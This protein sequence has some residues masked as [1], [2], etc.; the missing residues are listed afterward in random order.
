MIHDLRDISKTR[1]ILCRVRPSV[2]IH[3][4]GIS[5]PLAAQERPED[6]NLLHRQVTR[7]IAK[8]AE[9]AKA[10]V[11]FASSDFV[12]GGDSEF[13]YKEDDPA[14]PKT[15]YGKSKLAGEREILERKV[16]AVCRFSFLWGHTESEREGGWNEVRRRLESGETVTGITDEL[17]S[18]LRFDQAANAILKLHSKRWHGLVNV[19]GEI[20]MSPFEL[21]ELYRDELQSSSQIIPN[22][23]CEYSPNL[24]RPKNV[25]LDSE[26]FNS[27]KNQN[28][29]SKSI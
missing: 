1:E 26:R 16:G 3:L 28:D 13:P 25:T 18:P 15:I 19:G 8:Y 22:L 27:I 21:L 10:W 23:R 9:D 6:A 29:V 4:A 17:R 2:I 7:E 24:P 11:L 20:P 14:V 12:Y 5:S